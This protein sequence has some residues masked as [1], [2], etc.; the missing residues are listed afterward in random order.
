MLLAQMKPEKSKTL[1]FLARQVDYEDF[2][3]KRPSKINR[4]VPIKED[5]I[6]VQ[7]R[8]KRRSRSRSSRDHMK[9]HARYDSKVSRSILF[10]SAFK[11]IINF[12]S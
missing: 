5:F 9:S 1:E 2:S 10:D 12:K 6:D 3:H 7:L 8:Q 4:S 11:F